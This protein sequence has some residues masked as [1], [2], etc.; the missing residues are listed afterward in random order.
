MRLQFSSFRL[1]NCPAPIRVSCGP[2]DVTF[3]SEKF[4]S[5]FD[6]L[7]SLTSSFT[8][9]GD[10]YDGVWLVGLRQKRMRFLSSLF[11]PKRSYE[12]IPRKKFFSFVIMSICAKLNDFINEDDDDDEATITVNSI[13]RAGNSLDVGRLLGSL[14]HSKNNMKVRE[15]GNFFEKGLIKYCTPWRDLIRD[16][17]SLPFLSSPWDMPY[18]GESSN[19]KFR[20]GC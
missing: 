17:R 18:K 12:A 6:F 1:G 5:K 19:T 8:A 9:D 15:G 16:P 14:N 11:P 10:I 7:R 4:T 13:T 20:V 2:I 3:L